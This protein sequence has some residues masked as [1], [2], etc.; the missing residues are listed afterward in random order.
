LFLTNARPS[1]RVPV[2][3]PFSIENALIE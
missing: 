2:T 3:R 1:C